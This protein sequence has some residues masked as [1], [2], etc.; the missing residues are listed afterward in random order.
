MAVHVGR[1]TNHF[2]V[3][4]V[5]VSGT[6]FTILIYKIQHF[7]Q[8]VVAMCRS[9]SHFVCSLLFFLGF[10]GKMCEGKEKKSFLHSYRWSAFVYTLWNWVCLSERELLFEITFILY[11]FMI[12]RFTSSCDAQIKHNFRLVCHLNHSLWN[13]RWNC[14]K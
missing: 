13:W 12:F 8:L 1:V 2:I 9:L 7:S 6:I 5:Q 4:V 10:T 3:H 11:I 14:T